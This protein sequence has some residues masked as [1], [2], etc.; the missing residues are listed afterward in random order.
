MEPIVSVRSVSKRYQL[1]DSPKQRL[2]DALLPFGRRSHREFWALR[3]ISLEVPRGQA[4]G[5]IGR[6]GCGKS[7]LL[8]IVCGVLRP[9]AG[10]VA[11]H[12]R[13][14][15]LLELG[16]GFNPEYTGRNNAYMNL[17]LAGF[18]RDEIDDRFESIER[19]AEIGEFIDQPVKVY[20]TGLFVRLAFACAVS[21]DPDILVVDEA[22]GVGD[23]FFQQ[24]CFSR[25]REIIARGTTCLFVSHDTAAIMNLCQEAIL[26]RQGEMEFKGVPE[27]A[28]SRY[29]ASVVMPAAPLGRTGI[30]PRKISSQEIQG[31]MDPAEIQQ[32]NILWDNMD[33]HGQGGLQVVAARVLDNSG[34]D[35]LE[36]QMLETLTFFLLLRARE[37]ITDPSTGIHLLDRMGNVLFA[38]GTR[39][40]RMELPSLDAGEQLVVRL[41]LT[42]K[43]QSGEYTFT[44]GTSAPWG[45]VRD[46]T[47]QLGPIVVQP[48]KCDYPLFHGMVQLPLKAA[49][50]PVYK[51]NR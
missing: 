7:T 15:A 51:R 8:Q 39:E 12:G 41:E 28:V 43:V 36:V 3:D 1:Y 50:S 22:L 30:D 20:S 6:N 44:L 32:N 2:K 9:S 46:R 40:L 35:T 10:Q 29:W 27:E 49:F 23:V 19:F 26:L 16:A 47:C 37:P 38:A 17:A 31:M 5:I 21:A 34:R 18:S 14:S 24:K 25:I 13:V 11:T 45:C 42:F 33:R 4:L 48:P